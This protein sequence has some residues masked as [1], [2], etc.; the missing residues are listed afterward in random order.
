[1]QNTAGSNKYLNTFFGIPFTV[2]MGKRA[3][4]RKGQGMTREEAIN[5]LNL[6][7]E[8]CVCACIEALEMA[9]EALKAEPCED[10]ISRQAALDALTT[11][12]D[13]E[14][15]EMTNGGEYIDYEMTY[16]Y[17]EELPPVNPIKTGYWIDDTKCG[18]TECSKCGKWYPHATIAKSEIKYCSEC[19][20]KMFEPQESEVS[21]ADSN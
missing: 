21:D 13:T 17:V 10:A 11:A 8:Y 12:R 1:M 16:G 15:V 18:G 4:L 19:G 20:A 7:K 5:N 3:Y 9:I 2:V 6:S 14:C